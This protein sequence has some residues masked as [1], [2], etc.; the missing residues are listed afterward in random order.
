MN[1][2]KLLHHFGSRLKELRTQRNISQEYLANC[3]QFDRTYI[4]GL[5]RGIRNP[6][7]VC[8]LQLAHG[9]NIEA[10]KLIAELTI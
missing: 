6:S 5:E 2:K 10:E 3:C 4:S 1:K 8:I 9:L 7:L